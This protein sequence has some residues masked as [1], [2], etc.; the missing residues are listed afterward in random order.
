MAYTP[1]STELAIWE[2][3][4][5][6]LKYAATLV[7]SGTLAMALIEGRKKLCDT[8]AKF[9]R[10]SILRWLGN[11]PNSLQPRFQPD[12][13]WASILRWLR[14]KSKGSK[15]H[16][17]AQSRSGLPYD[18]GKAYEQLLLLTTGLGSPHDTA[19]RFID[20]VKQQKLMV[21]KYNRSVEYAL[22]ELKIDRLMGQ[23]Q[24]AADVA[25]NN[26][27]FYPDFFYF[28]TRG[29][30][31]EDVEA[32]VSDITAPPPKAIND[33]KRKE[34]ADR[35]TR[36]KQAVRKHLDSFQIVT[37]HR[38]EEWNQLA[39]AIL[40]MVVLLSAQL[41]VLDQK[42]C[43]TLSD[44]VWADSKWFELIVSSAFGGMLAPAAKDFSDFLYK[45]K[46]NG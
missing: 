37:T 42:G 2:I 24:D 28:L 35:Y 23:V 44:K 38:W 26:P 45:N 32:W 36:L 46:K 16:Y 18:P 34:I 39:A 27:S 4:D 33:N 7:A 20:S 9:H 13:R 40:G 41:W 15:H 29:V 30:S 19:T 5:F 14:N 3:S 17:F 10:A 8:L 43:G 31:K 21:E 12:Y 25:L 22:F 11:E 6:V 1:T